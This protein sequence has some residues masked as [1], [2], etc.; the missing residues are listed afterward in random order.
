VPELAVWSGDTV[1]AD[2]EGFLYF[3]G[4]SDDM[5]KTSGYRVSP[6]EVESVA[7]GTG[8][9]SEAAAFWRSTSPLGQAIVLIAVGRAQDGA[10]LLAACKRALPAY[11]VPAQIEM[12]EQ[13]LPRNPQW[14]DRPQTVGP[15]TG[16]TRMTPVHEEQRQ[17]PVLDDNCQGIGG[18]AL[19]RLAE[20]VGRTPF[21]AYERSHIASRIA[22]LR[23][24]LPAGLELHY[25]VKANPMPA[26]AQLIAP[27]VDGLMWRP[28]VK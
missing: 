22:L 13:R 2:E 7:Y 9:V 21:Y 8:L 28:V 4:R 19:T 27:L 17:F 11:M 5:I 24:T 12:R 26:V 15:A 1:S 18:I 16:G 25:A 6:A 20:R 10:V 14:Q 3:I 23:Q